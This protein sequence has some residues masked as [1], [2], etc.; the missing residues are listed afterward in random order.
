MQIVTVDWRCT[1]HP[2]GLTEAMVQLNMWPLAFSQDTG[3][4]RPSLDTTPIHF[5]QMTRTHPCPFKTM[6]RLN[7]NTD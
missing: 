3:L 1:V 7:C 4:A 6:P 2:P 5:S